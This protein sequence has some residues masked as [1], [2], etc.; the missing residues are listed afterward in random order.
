MPGR[1]ERIDGHA[2]IDDYALI[3]DGRTGALV[4]R[5]GA[6]DW[7]C[8]PNFDSDAVFAALLDA[9]RGGTF[10]ITP[11]E[12][13][14]VERR[15]AEGTNVLETTFRTADGVVRLTDAMCLAG[16]DL[17]PMRQLV[18]KIEGL[19]GHVRLD[20][21]FEPRFGYG[22]RSTSVRTTTGRIVASS[23]SDAASL[24]AFGCR[25]EAGPA[26]AHGEVAVREGETVLFDLALAS[27]EPLVFSGRD[28]TE[29]QLER[30]RGFWAS[31]S[32]RAE[33]D[34]RWRDA[35]IRSALVLKLL[36]FSP[37]G[38]IVAA[39]TTSLP[40][41]LGGVRNWDYRFAWLRD[42][43]W[44]LDALLQLGYHDEAES[45]LWWFMHAS[46]LTHPQLNVLYRLDGS[47]HT[48]EQGLQLAGYRRSLPVRAG[49]SAARQ[50]QLD[51]YGHV[52]EALWLFVHHGGK[53]DAVT[54]KEVAELA[55]WAA[56][57][58]RQP[59]ASMWEVRLP[60]QQFIH[61][62]ALLWLAL[63]R[64]ARLADEGAIPDRRARWGPAAQ[65]IRTFVEEQGF[66]PE[67]NSYVRAP[68]LREV[69]AAILTVALVDWE[70]PDEQRLRATIDA[71]RRHL[72]VGPYVYRYRGDDGVP[73]GQ[74]AFLACSFWLADAL[75]GTG[76]LDEAVRLMDELV[77][78][79]NDV[80]LYAEEADPETGELLGNFPQALTHLAL[81]N[82]ALTIAQAEDKR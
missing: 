45:F 30:T 66:D 76:N 48:E 23:R 16:D 9:E 37:S 28:G 44:T 35:V 62:K 24:D 72:A 20:C 78:V 31:W 6:I 71:V 64:A 52:L 54:G 4:A 21:A 38:A 7:L 15:Y 3:G 73:G 1:P 42:A 18:R 25:L 75:A 57:N 51:V 49:N 80:G 63:D 36:V 47:S 39:P 41:E 17:G 70:G 32:G 58:W 12:P 27:K 34:G 33:Y 55:D 82:A 43:S 11:S 53:L 5:D 61:S 50:V 22:S 59:D 68:T 14:D 69:D 81:I 8:V 10:R 26:G 40:E 79:A 74:G 2:S 29:Q 67:L 56:E 19:S 60:P 65:E 46:R 13:F 77:G